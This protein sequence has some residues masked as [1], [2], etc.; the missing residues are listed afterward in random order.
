M[1]CLCEIVYRT[2]WGPLIWSSR[3]HLMLLCTGSCVLALRICMGTVLSKV[4]CGLLVQA[5]QKLLF[6]ILLL[7]HTLCYWHIVIWFN[8]LF[9][10]DRWLVRISICERGTWQQPFGSCWVLD[11]M[12][13]NCLS[14][15]LAGN[16]MYPA[17]KGTMRINVPSAYVSGKNMRQSCLIAQRCHSPVGQ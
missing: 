10:E 14:E 11:C 8:R 6:Y 7:V 4:Q 2:R 1:P 9:C 12:T 5:I 17:Q 13:F 15:G 16:H 3:A